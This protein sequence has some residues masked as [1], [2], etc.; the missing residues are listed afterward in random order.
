M[1]V[2][3]GKKVN[4]SWTEVEAKLAEIDRA[5][6]V[7]LVRDLYTASTDN[8]TFLHAPFY[9]VDDVLTPYK[10]TILRWL[11]PG[12]VQEPEHLGRQGKA[13]D[14]ELQEGCWPTGRVGGSDGVL[15]RTR[16]WVQQ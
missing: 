11:S 6:L 3:T 1:S 13:G 12:C 5:G 2:V 15:L 4:A 7:G 8:Q 9:L 16:I 14:F 10:A